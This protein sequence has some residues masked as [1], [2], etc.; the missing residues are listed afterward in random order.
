MGFYEASS[1]LELAPA[2]RFLVCKLSHE[3]E[4]DLEPNLHGNYSEMR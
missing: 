2:C 3:P 4:G 1:A